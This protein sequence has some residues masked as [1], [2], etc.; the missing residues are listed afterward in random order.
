MVLAVVGDLREAK[1]CDDWA[2]GFFGGDRGPQF[3]GQVARAPERRWQAH[4]KRFRSDDPRRST[5]PRLPNR[6]GHARGSGGDETPLARC[7]QDRDEASPH[8]DG[9]DSA[10][11][12]V[13]EVNCYEYTPKD[14]G[15][16][17]T[18]AP[19]PRAPAAAADGG[20]GEVPAAAPR[21][22]VPQDE[23]TR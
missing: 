23:W 4:K 13:N 9:G 14:P 16:Y 2:G 19:A 10:G 15:M 1:Q 17:H 5:Q 6:G 22:P 8:G 21:A 7:S 18:L 3:G 11:G 12:L 20:R